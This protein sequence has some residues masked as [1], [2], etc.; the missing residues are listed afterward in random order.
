VEYRASNEFDNGLG[1]KSAPPTNPVLGVA[2]NPFGNNTT[3]QTI[4]GSYEWA[5]EVLPGANNTDYE[6]A[7]VSDRSSTPTLYDLM[8]EAGKADSQASV[9][10]RA[11][12]PVFDPFGLND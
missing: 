7:T 10:A 3:S 6:G 11:S 9:R 1:G 4:P 2:T 5:L 12:S 8:T